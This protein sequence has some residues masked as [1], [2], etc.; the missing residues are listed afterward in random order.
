M[1][2][3]SLQLSLLDE[4]ALVLVDDREGLLQLLRGLTSQPTG[5]EELLVV[6]CAIGYNPCGRLN[7]K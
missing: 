6:E 7:K 5:G 2:S 4:P 3:V 1:Q